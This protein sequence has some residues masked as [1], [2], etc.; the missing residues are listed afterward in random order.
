M[1]ARTFHAFQLAILA[2]ASTAALADP[3]ELASWLINTTGATGYAGLPANVQQVRYSAG[4]VY[5]NSS[6]IPAYTIGPWPGNPNIPSNQSYVLRIPRNPTVNN[7][8]KTA[9]PL[10]AI[11]AWIT[12]VPVYNPLD[13]FSYNNQNIWHRNAIVVEGPS[14]DSCLGHPAPGGRYHH[15]QNPKCEY[16]TD[17]TRHSPILGYAFDGFPIYGPYAYAAADGTGGIT[18][19]RTSYRLRNISVRQTL[20]DGTVLTPSQYGPA[21]ST[22][23]PLGYYV[24]DFEYVSGLGDLDAY[25]GRFAITPEYPGGIYA[26]FVTIDATGASAYPYSVGPS[27]YGVVATDNITS[28]G[29]VTVSESVA[30]YTPATIPGRVLDT[31]T[32]AKVSPTTISVSWNGSC[33]SAAQNYGVYE[34]TIGFWY[35]HAAIDCAAVSNDRSAVITPADG[36]DYYLVVP[37]NASGEGS[38]GQATGS[39]EIPPGSTTCAAGQVLDACGF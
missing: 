2:F 7:G 11:G 33:S 13:A 37:R 16:S 22:T 35:S 4:S 6:G 17:S 15:H 8:T 18:R 30:T 14:F 12:G 39:V 1:T 21:V 9:T 20:P 3:P 26:Y 31:I 28:M 32:M 19:L 23:Y 10:G 34:G 36:D 27:Y 25:N 38:Y 29:R 5:L 24:E